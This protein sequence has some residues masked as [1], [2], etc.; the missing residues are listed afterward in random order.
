M[1]QKR[2][3]EIKTRNYLY[4][5]STW[6]RLEKKGHFWMMILSVTRRTLASQA[7][8]KLKVFWNMVPSN[9]LI[10][11]II[12]KERPYSCQEV[13]TLSRQS[14]L[15]WDIKLSSSPGLWRP[16]CGGDC[17]QRACRATLH[18]EIC[19]DHYSFCLHIW[20]VIHEKSPMLTRSLILPCSAK[21]FSK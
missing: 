17:K 19:I 1:R 14:I 9:W 3:Y 21:C 4:R 12:S 16:G 15:V 8:K 11:T 2:A 20:P 13:L 10:L 18:T 5:Y 7:W 6:N